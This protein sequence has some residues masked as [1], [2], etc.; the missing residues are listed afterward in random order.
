MSDL[1]AV[2]GD[3]MMR[4]LGAILGESADMYDSFNKNPE[5]YLHIMN[6]DLLP[7]MYDRCQMDGR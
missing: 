7:I 4:A 2:F 3:V 1:H 6:N 5:A